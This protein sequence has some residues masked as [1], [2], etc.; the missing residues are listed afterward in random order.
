MDLI[1]RQKAIEALRRDPM[2]GLNYDGIL[3]SLP[4]VEAEPVRHGHWIKPDDGCV[5]PFWEK[6]ICSECLCHSGKTAYCPSCG[7]KMERGER[8]I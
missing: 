5:R 1:D 7:A 8:W 6:Y 2:G 3:K 4:T